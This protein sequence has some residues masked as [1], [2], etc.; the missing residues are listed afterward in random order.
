MALYA[1]AQTL[2][3]RVL[4]PL[5]RFEGL[6]GEFSQ[7]NVGEVLDTY[8]DGTETKVHLR[9]KSKSHWDRA[10]SGTIEV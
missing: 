3:T 6:A 10:E 4:T 1:L 7:H 2:R 5:V 8:A 9:A